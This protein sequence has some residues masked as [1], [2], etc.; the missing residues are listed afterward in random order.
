MIRAVFFD[1]DGVILDSV[2]AKGEAFALDRIVEHHMAHGGMPRREKFRAYMALCGLPPDEERVDALCAEFSRIVI[3][4]MPSV[5]EVPGVRRFV[6]NLRGRAELFVI[7]AA[8]AADL[9]AVTRQRGLRPFFARLL[10]SEQSKA[11]HM[12]HLLAEHGWQPRQ[13]VMFGDS[14]GDLD[15]AREAGVPFVGV[16]GPSPGLARRGVP[17]I[18]DFTGLADNTNTFLEEIR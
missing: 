3:E 14:P 18:A 16:A 7:S 17:L 4:M 9:E 13:A 2:A 5:P 11:D 1:F 12:R 10:G 6:H 15:A 8:H